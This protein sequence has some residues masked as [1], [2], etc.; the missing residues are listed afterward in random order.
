[1][2]LWFKKFLDVFHNA[3]YVSQWGRGRWYVRYNDGKRTVLMNFSTAHG[4]AE[5]FGGTVKH[6]SS[7]NVRDTPNE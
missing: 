4:Y 5:I 3:G 7:L 6:V 2:F 1:M